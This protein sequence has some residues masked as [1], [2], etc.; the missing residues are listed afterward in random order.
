[1]CD[2][3]IKVA[4]ENAGKM[5]PCPECS[6]IVRVP[7]PSKKEVTDW[8]KV[9]TGP[10]LARKDTEAAPEGAW[11]SA[12]GVA[13][14]SREALEEAAA[15][16]AESAPR[17]RAQ[18]IKLLLIAAAVLVALG[19]AYVG[20]KEMVAGSIQEQAL[21]RAV[22][23]LD[24]QKSKVTLDPLAVAEINRAVGEC[25]IHMGNEESTKIGR[26]YLIAAR[27]KLAN[28][29]PSGERDSL[30]VD[31]AAL[32]ADLVLDP[33]Q[34][35]K[36]QIRREAEREQ[37]RSIKE[38]ERTISLIGSPEARAE[39]LRHGTQMLVAKKLG[40]Q[41]P[42]LA[43]G[44]PERAEDA[45]VVGIE[46]WKAG[47]V[48]AAT[49]LAEQLLKARAG[50]KTAKEKPAP[51]ALV[52]L[53]VVLKK[54]QEEI[55]SNLKL[56][57][58]DLPWR[59][60]MIQGLALSGEYEKARGIR[61]ELKDSVDW[62]QAGAIVAL[63]AL[64]KKTADNKELSEIAEW[65]STGA[66][67]GELA[68]HNP[69]LGRPNPAWMLLRLVQQSLKANKADVAAQLAEGISDPQLR[70]RAKLEL[71]RAKLNAAGGSAAGDDWA[72]DIDEKSPAY[73]L[74]RE[75]IVRHNAKL[76]QGSA[77]L[78]AVGTWEPEALR[79]FGYVGVGLGVQG[80]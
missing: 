26:Q 58:N 8:R 20:Y 30:L 4:I 60:G 66:G 72:K 68:G 80:K 7:L 22:S 57:F 23:Y 9:S 73:G 65:I 42:R 54:P 2:E 56:A 51:A 21:E 11:G 75:A 5:A 38:L 49:A 29:E 35:E 64:D 77:L 25:S 16:S 43:A 52:A 61:A 14:V 33:G 67:K 70:S 24:P 32:Q 37:E 78:K 46:L 39:A 10:S 34:I 50:E 31:I 53:C 18:K 6:R 12:T 45:A 76:G 15:V 36:T 27:T 41:A 19:G 55:D 44:G 69:A 74:A 71:L 47:Q 28:V 13:T 79:P 17:T 63:A 3:K 40:E 1:M 48:P 59:L 62:F